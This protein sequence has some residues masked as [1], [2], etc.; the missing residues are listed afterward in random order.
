MRTRFRSERAAGG[1]FRVASSAGEFRAGALVVA[2]G[3]L[4]IPKLGATGLATSWRGSSGWDVVEPRPALVPLLLGGDEAGWTEL[5][6][7]AAEVEAQ[8]G[9]KKDSGR[10]CW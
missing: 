1:G 9:G 8:A 3:G 2:T 7:V 6:G 5:A 4:S 10:R